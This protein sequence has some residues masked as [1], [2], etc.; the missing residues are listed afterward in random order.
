MQ[1][2]ELG[3]GGQDMRQLCKASSPAPGGNE[4]SQ[5][6]GIW[7]A[8]QGYAVQTENSPANLSGII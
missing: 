5:A 3:R 7:I 6:I 2:E 1:G 8:A 4:G